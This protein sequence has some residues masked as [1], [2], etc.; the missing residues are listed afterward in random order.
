MG[1]RALRVSEAEWQRT[2]IEC[3]Q[4]NGWTVAHFRPARTQRGWRTPVE[5]D[6]AGF[7]DLVLARPPELL[8]VEL[9]S[10]TGVVRPEQQR[11]L[12][13]LSEVEGAVNELVLQ[14]H[15]KDA[16]LTGPRVE[17]HVWRPRD[18]G[19]ARHRLS[20]RAQVTERRA[21]A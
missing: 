15:G 19:Y 13:A 6:G 12:D 20:R 18:W 17:V 7:P 1:S 10:D 4:V 21:V 16:G 14:I 8:F 11:W 3:A 5:A 9:K 2:V